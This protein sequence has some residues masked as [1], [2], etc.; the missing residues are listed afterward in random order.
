MHGA[1]LLNFNI[2]TVMPSP[3]LL[4][5]DVEDVKNRR[6]NSGRY[7]NN[8]NKSL[9][10]ESAKRHFFKKNL[11]QILFIHH[12]KLSVSKLSEV[13]CSA[14]VVLQRV[15]FQSAGEGSGELDPGEG[16]SL[17]HSQA[18]SGAGLTATLERNVRV[19]KVIIFWTLYIRLFFR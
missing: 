18:M 14:A 13:A 8:H 17:L 5:K 6:L 7:S 12:T 16:Y 19:G 4:V 15:T 1:G 11:L 10:C 2:D 3:C 9:K